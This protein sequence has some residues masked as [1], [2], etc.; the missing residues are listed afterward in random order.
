MDDKLSMQAY[1]FTVRPEAGV[2]LPTY[3]DVWRGRSPHP[4][5]LMVSWH[6]IAWKDP[7]T[8]EYHHLP[9]SEVAEF[10]VNVATPM[11]ETDVAQP[12]PFTGGR[13]RKLQP[14]TKPGLILD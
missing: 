3:F 9:W 4:G 11:E 13:V 5:R 2:T 14:P 8:G 7:S 1:E 10:M 12:P 6:G